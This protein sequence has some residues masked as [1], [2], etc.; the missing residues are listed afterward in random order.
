MISVV[1][2]VVFALTW[3]IVVVMGWPCGTLAFHMAYSVWHCMVLQSHWIATFETMTACRARLE[4]KDWS[5]R[6][7]CFD[8]LHRLRPDSQ[9]SQG[10]RSHGPIGHRFGHR[11]GA[12]ES[13]SFLS[14]FEMHQF[15]S[16][17]LAIDFC[18][19]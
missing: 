2:Q 6:S 8:C 10:R 17:F 5:H 18:C 9:G 4:D 13:L 3:F 7:H 15:T 12:P 14:A 1:N 19:P 11:F 16:G